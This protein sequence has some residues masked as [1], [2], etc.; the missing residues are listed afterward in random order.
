MPLSS[1][2]HAALCK[3]L[4]EALIASF[5]SDDYLEMML[6]DELTPPLPIPTADT[7]PL[8]VFK[9]IKDATTEG[10]LR[11]L[12]IGASL[13]KPGNPELKQFIKEYLQGLIEEQPMSLPSSDLL[14]S[15]IE[16]LRPVA[17]FT[18]IV[19]SAFDQT[20]PDIEITALNLREQ[21]FNN[22]LSFDL[23]WLI[24]LGLLLNTYDGRDAKGQLYIVAFV[25]NLLQR[26]APG[27]TQSALTQW[28]DQLPAEL[29]P[30]V[31]Q[32]KLI[33]SQSRPSDLALQ[34]LQA[35]FLITV[36]PPEIT[37]Q[38]EQFGVNGYLITRL[39]D[40]EQFTRFHVLTLQVPASSQKSGVNSDASSQEQPTLSPEAR[41]QTKG[42]FCTLQQIENYLPDWLLQAQL[43]IDRQCTELQA[44]YQLE[45]RP[46]YDLTVEFWLP[47][48]HLTAAADTWK[49]YSKPVRLKRRNLSIGKEYRVVVRSYDR[50]SDPDS[51][52]ELNRTWQALESLDVDAQHQQIHHLDSWNACTILQQQLQQACLGLSLTCPICIQ[53]PERE[54]LFAWILENG[55]PI[56]LWSRCT[57]LSEDQ[58]TGLKEKMQAL[59]TADILSQLDQM[60]ENLKQARKLADEDQLALWCDE[61]QRLIELKQLRE[62]GRLR[63]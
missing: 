12:V 54:E 52:N 30:A 49:V 61:P 5:P 17:D 22:E 50:F 38:T 1:E 48:E 43:A 7:Y 56:A 28:L 41:Q 3:A 6:Q 33:T 59:L 20:L 60:L 31:P 32:S 44:R 57:D 18:G 35:H 10:R 40:D 53:T 36:E 45:F 23:K 24:L 8:R 16:V 39:D 55:I 62:R 2:Q 11:D 37:A 29:Q 27:N 25:H 42:L 46:V 19:L 9:L 13:A 51:L 34:N 21:L 63:A 58:K 15:L 4:R 47:F 14:T 26:L